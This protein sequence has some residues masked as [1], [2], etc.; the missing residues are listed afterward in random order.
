MPWREHIDPY[1]VVVSEIMLQQTQVQRV[2]E[3]FPSFIRRFPT[4]KKLALA[5]T[6]DALSEWSGLGYNRRALYLKRI[7]E[8]I[9][10]GGTKSGSL[11]STFDEL[12]TLP[13]IG[14]NTAG[15]I[16]AFGYNIPHPFIETNIRSVYIHFFFAN[17]RKVDDSKILPLIEQSLDKDNPREWYYALMDHGAHLKKTLPNPSRTSAHHVKQSTF[18]GSNREL[19]SNILRMILTMSPSYKKLVSH[20]TKTH[21]LEQIQTNLVNLEKEGFIIRKKNRYCVV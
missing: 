1:H 12:R 3:K 17:K 14:P 6:T 16:L 21:P 7:A 10:D 15:S 8:Q 4:W 9:T 2:M 18:K 5:S 13:G 11:P 19:R 20:F